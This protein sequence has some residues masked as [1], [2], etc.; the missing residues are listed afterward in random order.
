MRLH[1][2]RPH[3]RRRHRKKL[4]LAEFAELGFSIR[5]TEPA[6]WREAQPDP[7][8]ELIDTQGWLFDGE[9]SPL[10][11]FIARFGGGSLTE[12]DRELVRQ[13]LLEQG[14]DDIALGALQDR[15]EWVTQSR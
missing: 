3:H 13:W 10:D 2:L 14:A 9:R 15:W 8:G 12:V 4:R 7:L 5:G 1:A 11:G 6:A